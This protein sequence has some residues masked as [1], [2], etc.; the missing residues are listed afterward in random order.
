MGGEMSATKKFKEY[1][2]TIMYKSDEFGLGVETDIPVDF[3]KA[4][5]YMLRVCADKKRNEILPTLTV[6]AT[7][8]NELQ[9]IVNQIYE[10]MENDSTV[11]HMIESN[12]ERQLLKERMVFVDSEGTYKVIE[13]NAEGIEK[14]Q[15]ARWSANIENLEVTEKMITETKKV[16]KDSSDYKQ[17]KQ[18]L[19]KYGFE[20]SDNYI[21]W[22]LSNIGKL[23]NDTLDKVA[24]ATNLSKEDNI[25]YKDNYENFFKSLSERLE[26]RAKFEGIFPDSKVVIE[27]ITYDGVAGR[28]MNVARGNSIF[29]NAIRSSSYKSPDN[30][31]KYEII[32]RTKIGDFANK[33]KNP[34][35]MKKYKELR[36]DKY[37]G[38]EERRLFIN[39]IYELVNVMDESFRN[40]ESTAKLAMENYKQV[41]DAAVEAICSL[42]DVPTNHVISDVISKTLIKKAVKDGQTVNGAKIKINHSLSIK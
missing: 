41:F 5:G 27:G 37:K 3:I 30:K 11:K 12:L 26:N 6:V 23:D 34:E 13:S 10:D 21:K 19:A 35:F 14:S 39:E 1:L 7:L 18:E 28:L 8:D 29:D 2:S 15:I 25:L 38:S 4:Y 20:F 31:T 40:G 22:C 36:L 24:K 33:L 32:M 16:L 42:D 17:I 9:A